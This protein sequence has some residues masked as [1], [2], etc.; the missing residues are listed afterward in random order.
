MRS[1]RVRRPRA[2]R[3]GLARAVSAVAMAAAITVAG[4]VAAQ[5]EPTAQTTCKPVTVPVTVGGLTGPMSGTLCVPAGATTLQIL[6]HGHTYNRHFWDS[7]Y[8]PDTYSYVQDMN[9]AGY[10]TLAIDRLGVGQSFRPPS[11]LVTYDSTVDTTHAFV[12]AARGGDFGTTFSD[13]VLVGH[14]MGTGIIYGVA[15]KYQDTDALVV[16]GGGHEVDADY[17]AINY[18]PQVRPAPLDPKFAGK[19]LD[20]GYITTSDHNIFVNKDNIDPAALKLNQTL[21]KDVDSAV[22]LLTYFATFPA[23]RTMLNLSKNINVPTFT[24]NGQEDP[25]FCRA[26]SLLPDHPL[27][28]PDCSTAQTLAN[29]E[30]PFYGPNATVEAAVVPGTGHGATIE[31]TAPIVYDKITDFVDRHVGA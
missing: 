14:S 31:R 12:S 10:A 28:A 26:A 13:V 11:A 29:F 21:L 7:P 8:E 30:R 5:A 24:I 27:Q 6:V 23:N 22:A 18:T 2:P 16:V 1:G 9:E 17:V 20:P 3:R 19:V 15:G 25:F 4:S